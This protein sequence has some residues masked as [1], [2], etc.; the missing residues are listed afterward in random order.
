MA[1]KTELCKRY[2][3]GQDCR[4][5]QTCKFAHGVKELVPKE[6]RSDQY[7]V[8]QCKNWK[9]SGNC[10]FSTRCRFLHDER[11]IEVSSR[12]YWLVSRAE[13]MLRIISKPVEHEWSSTSN[14]VLVS[15]SPMRTARY[16]H[17]YIDPSELFE[18]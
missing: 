15:S 3:E 10:P 18:P 4:F 6:E 14:T 16:P 17:A 13:N 5:G 11:R 12:T 8:L 2:L 9:K 7:K 1:E